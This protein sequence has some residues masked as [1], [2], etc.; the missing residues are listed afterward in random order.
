MG[1]WQLTTRLRPSSF[2]VNLPHA[3]ADSLFAGVAISYFLRRVECFEHGPV[4]QRAWTCLGGR[5]FSGSVD[6]QRDKLSVWH[7]GHV[8][9]FGRTF[10]IY[11]YR[12]RLKPTCPECAVHGGHRVI[13]MEH[14]R[15]A[16]QYRS[17]FARV[18]IRDGHLTFLS[19]SPDAK[20]VTVKFTAK[21]PA[22]S[23]W[24]GG[25]VLSFFRLIECRRPLS[26][27]IET[28]YLAGCLPDTPRTRHLGY[29]SNMP[30][31]A[32]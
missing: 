11:S 25:E 24:D 30:A 5:Q 27:P 3:L 15:Y 1:R 2:G 29:R 20:W 8:R 6:C 7:V 26:T 23:Q 17:D 16:G 12:Y 14:G 9:E 21:G 31:T 13:F 32:A 28:F 18:A 4:P 10:E 22:K 19:D